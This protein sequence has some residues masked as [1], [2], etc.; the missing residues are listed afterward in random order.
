MTSAPITL[1]RCDASPAIG[2][3]HVSRC[4]ALAGQLKAEHGGDVHFVMREHGGK[5]KH[6]LSKGYGLHIMD[7]MHSGQLESLA[8]ELKARILFLDVRN[9]MDVQEVSRLA[10]SEMLIAVLDDPE[11][12]AL[13]ADVAYFPPVQAVLERD[14]SSARGRIRIGWD[15]V[16]IDPSFANLILQNADKRRDILVTMG[17]SDPHG[18]TIPVLRSLRTVPESLPVTVV[19]GPGF[20]QRDALKEEMAALHHRIVLQEHMQ[21]LSAVM[22]RSRLCLAAY[23]VTAY[24]LAAAGVP[25]VLISST[26]S[27]LG[28]RSFAAA[29]MAVWLGVWPGVSEEQVARTLQRFYTDESA[30]TTMSR[31]SCRHIDGRG[32]QRIAED[33]VR[34]ATEKRKGKNSCVPPQ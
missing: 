7:G 6:I 22:A 15:W 12:K 23:G 20:K 24:E 10:E 8:S 9:D 4:L 30:L 33:V 27:H 14:F 31:A 1:I 13:A 25:M 18:L 34:L 2:Y 17:G 5:D 32:G 16:V 26:D 3:G 19:I 21:D 11:S 28:A 29:G